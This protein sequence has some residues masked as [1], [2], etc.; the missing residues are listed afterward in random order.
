MSSYTK[1]TNFASKDALPSGNASKIVK[2][3]EIDT[4]FNN[5]SIAMGTKMDSSV[6]P[7]VS[8]TVTPTHT[9]LNYVAGVTSAIQTQIDTKAAK[10][11]AFSA[12]AGT[13][14]SLVSGVATKV[15]FDTEEFDASGVFAA[16]RFTVPSGAAGVYQI[17]A[18]IRMATQNATVV[19]MVYK[20]GSLARE[21][22]AVA[23][24]ANQTSSGSTLLSLAVGDYI[25]IFCT[26]GAATQNC[27][28]GAPYTW[29]QGHFIGT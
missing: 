1:S 14:T 12:Y 6:F 21:I 24:S 17:S 23:Q 2:G 10:G 15:N 9:Q 7:N 26:Q 19:L 8:G 11:P 3:T 25:E 13:A 20:N 27:S 18:G 4:E 22:G 28:T 16:S 29:F 5:I